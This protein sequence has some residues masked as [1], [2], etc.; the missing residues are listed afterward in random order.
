MSDP[1]S[2]LNEFLTYLTKERGYSEHTIKAYQFDLNRFI[3]FLR[4]YFSRPLSDFTTVDRQ[5]IRHFLSR[6]FEQ[7]R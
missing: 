2:L 6:E 7:Y 4:E 1:Q 3:S 5:A